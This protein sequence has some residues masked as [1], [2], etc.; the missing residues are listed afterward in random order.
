MRRWPRRRFWFVAGLG[1]LSA[2]LFVLTL[3]VLDWIEAVFR[4]DPDRHSG[5]L[6]WGIVVVLAVMS[7][8]SGLLARGEWRRAAVGV[9]R[10]G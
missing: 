6:E 9:F 10:A 5:L 4:V 2:V 3:F 1:A 8:G 7:V